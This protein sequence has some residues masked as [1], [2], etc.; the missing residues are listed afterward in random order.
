MGGMSFC[1]AAV[2][3]R[4]LKCGWLG[5]WTGCRHL[6]NPSKWDYRRIPRSLWISSCTQLNRQGAPQFFELITVFLASTGK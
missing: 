2:P 6:G 3:F 1:H 4:L 5:S